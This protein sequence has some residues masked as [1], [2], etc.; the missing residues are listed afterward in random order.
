MELELTTK[1]FLVRRAIYGAT[2]SLKVV[3]MVNGK[4]KNRKH[5]NVPVCEVS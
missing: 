4:I 3:L 5:V 1:R 2:P